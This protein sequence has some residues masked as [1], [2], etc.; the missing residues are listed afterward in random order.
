MVFEVFQRPAPGRQAGPQ[1]LVRVS[2]SQGVLHL[3]KRAQDTLGDPGWVLLWRDGDSIAITATPPVDAAFRC[4]NGAIGCAA[5]IRVVGL[6]PGSKLKLRLEDG[7]L[8]SDG[9]QSNG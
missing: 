4:V 8:R 5:F 3:N 2:S 1:M 6:I 7:R 9:K